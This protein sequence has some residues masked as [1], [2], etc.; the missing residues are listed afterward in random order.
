MNNNQKYK[1]Y[2]RPDRKTVAIAE[3]V[4]TS[5]PVVDRRRTLL[6]MAVWWMRYRLPYHIEG[7]VCYFLPYHIGRIVRYFRHVG[8]NLWQL[9]WQNR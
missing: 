5:V 4:Y 1:I 2:Y 7:V 8:R 6:S 9:E 3:G